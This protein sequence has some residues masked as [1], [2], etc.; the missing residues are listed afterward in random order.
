M[1]PTIMGCHCKKSYEIISVP[2]KE[3]ISPE[4]FAVKACASYFHF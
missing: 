4:F 2:Y 3:T 1:N